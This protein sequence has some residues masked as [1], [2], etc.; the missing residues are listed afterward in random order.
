MYVYYAGKDDG[1]DQ[2]L[3]ILYC[4]PNANINITGW[5]RT[6]NRKWCGACHMLEA[7][8]ASTLTLLM[9]PHKTAEFLS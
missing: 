9:G 3:V 8:S 5:Q 2:E 1:L 7:L 4:G 6:N